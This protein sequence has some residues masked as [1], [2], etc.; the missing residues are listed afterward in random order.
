MLTLV[1]SDLKRIDLIAAS[2]ISL[3]VLSK[4]MNFQKSKPKSILML[5]YF[6]A[7]KLTSTVTLGIYQTCCLKVTCSNCI[8]QLSQQVYSIKL[9]ERSVNN[10]PGQCGYEEHRVFLEKN[11]DFI[12]PFICM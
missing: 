8:I 3:L 7:K 1:W 6:L 11:M 10:A 2:L 9:R 4:K 12:L 5:S